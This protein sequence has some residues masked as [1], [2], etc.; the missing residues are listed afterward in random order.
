MN[1]HSQAFEGS[2]TFRERKGDGQEPQPARLPRVRRESTP[3]HSHDRIK[4]GVA[5]D[6]RSA[7]QQVLRL[8]DRLRFDPV[9]IGPLANG[10][11]LEP[12]GSPV[13]AT[14]SADELLEL[15]TR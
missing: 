3:D 12:D 4:I 7:V 1:G 15:A 14:Y 11:S 5:G 8:I 2:S 10:V 13:A 6:D 9:D